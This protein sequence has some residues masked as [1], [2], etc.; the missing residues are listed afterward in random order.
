METI[1]KLLL[2]EHIQ[3]RRFRDADI[4]A[5]VCSRIPDPVQVVTKKRG[6]S[7]ARAALPRCPYTLAEHGTSRDAL[8]S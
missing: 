1:S 6:N 5:A 7:L 2:G 8:A 3:A 4:L